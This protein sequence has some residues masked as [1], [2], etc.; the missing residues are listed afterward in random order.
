MKIFKN[1][2]YIL[3]AILILSFV[4]RIYNFKSFYV[5]SHD[6]DLASWIIKDIVVNG[7]NRLIGQETSS[8]GVFIGAL[9]Y[10]MQIPF[11]ILSNM[12][13]MGAI[14]MSIILGVF[15]TFS[16]YFVFSRLANTKVGLIGSFIHAV[17]A[18]I[19]FTD[20]E[21]APTMPVVLWT[22][23]YLYGLHLIYKDKY[24][25]GFVLVGLLVGLI[26][27]LNLALV[28]LLPLVLIAFLFSSKKI[29]YKAIV[30]GLAV[31]FVTSL[32]LIL[33]EYKHNFSQTKAVYLSLTT[34]KDLRVSSSKGYPKFDR[35]MQLVN[36]NTIG[37]FSN[38]NFVRPSLI[39]AILIISLIYLVKAKKIN[40][41]LGVTFS[42]W[43]ILYIAFFTL[44]SLNPSEYYFNGMNIV[45]MFIASSVLSELVSS[46]KLRKYFYILATL[47]L[48]TNI[49][50]IL[51]FNTDKKGYVEKMALVTHIN[52]DRIKNGYP[53][54]SISYITKPGYD[55]G[56]RYLFWLNNMH[57]NNP[58]SNSPVYT[59]VYPHSLVDKIDN[60]FGSL[61]LIYPD[62]SMY[63][64]K[65]IETSCGGANSN[66]TDPMFGY[67][68]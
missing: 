45:W 30:I 53:C 48:V 51:R 60:S 6:Q 36:K 57:V 68:E 59:I 39:T 32:P 27:H 29:N 16:I 54:I 64:S 35:V 7:H 62:Y 17:S 34:E 31:L 43:L 41:F 67:T 61:G 20:R 18:L 5:F 22:V 21:V 25:N 24:L 56:Y 37:I 15:T 23:W 1:Q 19:V 8:Q 66:L 50:F 52:E 14:F 65:D 55:L 28:L 58:I 46:K 42:F 44:N 4:F 47:F 38:Y 2:K 11:Y 63:N 12:N 33:F 26:W 49:N 9:Y 40:R 13:P 10:Y 3:I